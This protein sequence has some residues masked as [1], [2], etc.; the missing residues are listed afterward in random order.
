[1]STNCQFAKGVRVSPTSRATL[2]DTAQ[3]IRR[4]LKLENKAYFPVVE[5]LEV[6]QQTVEDFD[7]QI[8][9]DDE[10]PKGMFANYNPVTGIVSIKEK[11]YNMACTGNGFARWT[12]LHECLHH[13]LHRNQMAALSRQDNEPHKPYEDSEWQA[14]ALACELLMPMGMLNENM[15]EKEVAETFGVSP[16]AARNRLKVFDF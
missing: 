10:L 13:I 12:L 2:R 14:D 4:A 6:M 8:V 16:K 5:F 9:T 1:M 7:F 15:S 3:T 11:Y